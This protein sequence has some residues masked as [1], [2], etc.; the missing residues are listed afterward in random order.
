MRVSFAVLLVAAALAWSTE[1]EEATES[2][3]AEDVGPPNTWERPEECTQW[4]LSGECERNA[5]FMLDRCAKACRVAGQV[6]PAYAKRCPRGPDAMAPGAMRETFSRIM[7]DFGDLQPEMLSEDPPIVLFHAFASDDELAALIAH[8]QGRYERSLGVHVDGTG[9][10]SSVK[11]EIRT[12]SHAWCMHDEC[13][14]D[15]RVQRFTR[16]IMNVTQM[17]EE[18]AEYAQLVYYH[19]CDAE[20]ANDCAFYRRHSDY[21]DTDVTKAQ[22][23]RVFTLFAYLND[24]PEGGGTRFTD[25]T[26][27]VTVEPRRGKALLWPSVQID[28]P[29]KKDERT[30][31]EAL[32]V[33]RGEKYGANVWIHQRDFKTNL[34]RGCTT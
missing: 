19:A 30:M 5:G 6:S 24:V 3:A 4:A 31:H 8:G 29:H 10:V 28:A 20:D 17:P 14:A 26:P 1:A 18:N 21:I 2:A 15:E 22:G 11:T 27:S 34:Q 16:R 12:S 7:R 13:L 25:L 32:P 23:V 9:R 33:L